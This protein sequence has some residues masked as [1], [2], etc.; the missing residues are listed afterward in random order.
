[1]N[2]EAVLSDGDHPLI[3]TKVKELTCDRISRLD[4]LESL[5]Y[6]VRDDIQ[7]G[8]PP[9]WDNVRASETLRYGIGYC[10]T[11]AALLLALCKAASIPAR[12]HTG[13]IDI[14]IMRGIFPSFAFPFLPLIST[15]KCNA[16]PGSGSAAGQA[17]RLSQGIDPNG[18]VRE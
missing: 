14:E 11:K 6:F 12:I 10:N 16:D 7:F 1:M 3:R 9:K 18:R 4:K 2:P 17:A 13:L 8:F 15:A 5:C